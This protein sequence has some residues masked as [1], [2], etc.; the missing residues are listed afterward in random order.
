MLMER[1]MGAITFKKG[2][3]S[4]TANDANFTNTAWLIVL[5]VAVLNRLGAHGSIISTKF[6]GW[7]ISGIILGALGV[8][9]FALSA[10]LIVWLANTMFKASVKFEQLVRAMGLAY[11]WQ[12][13]GVVGVFGVLLSCLLAPITFLA[14]LAGLAA[15][16]FAIK[17][18]TNMDWTGT[19]V[20]A[21]LAWVVT[22]VVFLVAASILAVIGLL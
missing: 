21:V 14:G 7:L 6:I 10:Y 17:E 2:I 5:V 1:I 13:I 3:Y 9:A 16:L 18:T 20:C 8:A 22:F 15:N 12:V 19:V 4:Q 11:V